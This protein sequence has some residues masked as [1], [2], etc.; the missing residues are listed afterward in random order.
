MNTS[1]SGQNVSTVVVYQDSFSTVLTK[2]VI[3]LALGLTILYINGTLIHTFRKH[4]VLYMN[5][6]YIL[7]IHLVV[8]DMIQLTTSISLF[9]CA[10]L[11]YKIHGFLCCIIVS[12]ASFTTLN[13]PLNLAVMAVECYIA[14]CF[15]L[16]HS[17]LCTVRKIY[18]LIACIWTMSILSFLPDMLWLMATQSEQ[19]VFSTILCKL[20][21]VRTPVMVKKTEILNI[22]Y[23]VGVWLVLFYTYFRI[24]FAAR[25]AKSAD[26]ET[27]KARNTILLHSFQ[28]L[29]CMLTYVYPTVFQ[30][31]VFFSP[32]NG[33]HVILIWYVLVQ[34]FPRFL[35]PIVYGLRDTLFRQHFKK[36]LLCTLCVKS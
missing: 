26:S 21:R 20:D 27:N 11:F 7:F 4:Q 31:I 22:M 34:I 13:S 1:L 30:L 9:V 12:F 32:R 17:E 10:Y 3:V 25:S 8:N 2:N 6:R 23:L 18:R 35:S 28:L 5:P 36:H 33:E 14:V 24:F 16:R 29:L 19:L 15:P